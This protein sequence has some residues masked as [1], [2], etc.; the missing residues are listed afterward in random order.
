MTAAK[1]SRMKADISFTQGVWEVAG[2]VSGWP[3]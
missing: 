3:R 1:H 2:G